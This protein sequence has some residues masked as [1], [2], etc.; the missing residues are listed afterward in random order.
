MTN[1]AFPPAPL[2]G[3]AVAGV[4]DPRLKQLLAE[5]WEWSMRSWPTWATTLG[6]HRFDDRLPAAD[7]AVDC[8]ARCRTP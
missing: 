6:D 2:A 7:A 3:E 8:P 1:D 4:G 5:H